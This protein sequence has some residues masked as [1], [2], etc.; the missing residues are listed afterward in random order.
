[1]EVSCQ[2][3]LILNDWSPTSGPLNTS[4][5]VFKHSSVSM[6][7][8]GGDEMIVRLH[9]FACI[10][11]STRPVYH[12]DSCGLTILDDLASAS[13]SISTYNGQMAVLSK[14]KATFSTLV[15][16]LRRTFDQ[17]CGMARAMPRHDLHTHNNPTGKSLWQEL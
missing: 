14:M 6:S 9:H 8:S 10:V 15:L 7:Y 12:G 17:M 13:V 3:R 1:M 5:S 2:V 16:V 4:G 11:A